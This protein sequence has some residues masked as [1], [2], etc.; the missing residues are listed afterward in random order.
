MKKDRPSATA[1]LV[2]KALLFA[3][4]DP[5]HGGLVPSETVRWSE[6]IAISIIKFPKLF[7]FAIRNRSSRWL[8]TTLEE[9]LN[10]GFILHVAARKRFIDEIGRKSIRSGSSQIIVIGAGYDTFGLSAAISN[11]AANCF[12]IDHA[13]TQKAKIT[14]VA[15]SEI[16]P[17]LF[18]IPADL[19][20]TSIGEVLTAHPKFDSMAST[21]III[22][23]VLMYLP[24]QAARR[25]FEATYDL[26]RGGLTCI[27]TF[28]DRRSNA[29]IQ[30]KTAHPLIK[31]WLRFKHEQFLSGFE[32]AQLAGYLAT[33][34]FSHTDTYGKSEF[35]S[36]YFP[37]VDPAPLL[38]EGE[39]IG[40]TS[41]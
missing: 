17:N 2:L 9:T 32:K 26:F 7:L 37:K 41:K 28:M 22:E 40:V 25:F 18:F 27:F 23:G 15:S 1:S 13:T 16:P 36:E 12:E 20:A 30:F 11:P 3:A 38:A 5:I 31:S 19:S 35:I 24:A 29:D 4:Y 10:P 14:S 39:F 21:L 6:S 33:L 8:L 34:G